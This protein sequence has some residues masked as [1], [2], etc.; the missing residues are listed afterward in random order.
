MFSS[1]ITLIST[2]LQLRRD[3]Q[4]DVDSIG[5]RL[6][7]IE[8]VHLNAITHSLW[9][10]DE[11]EL[12]ITLEGLYNLPDMQFLEI[13]DGDKIWATVGS[14][15]SSRVI[16][17]EYDIVHTHQNQQL[18]IGTLTA[19][20]NLDAV[21]GRLIDKTIIILISN[22][23]KTFLVAGF[24]LIFFHYLI[25]RH[26]VGISQYLERFVTD[27]N[28][29]HPN[30]KL[31]RDEHEKWDELDTLVDSLNKLNHELTSSYHS[32]RDSEEKYRLAMNATSD[33]LWDFRVS[34]GEVYYSPGW[35][36]I[37]DEQEVTGEYK[38]W[39]SRIHPMDKKRIL[40]TL[41]EHLKGAT[42]QWEEEHRLKKSDGTW[43]WVLGRGKV[44]ERNSAG[45][46]LRMIGTMTEISQRKHAEERL[47]YQATHDELTGLINRYEFEKRT[48]RLLADQFSEIDTHALLFMDL[49]QFKVINDV[50]GH[51]AGDELLRQVSQRLAKIVRK[52]DT[53]ARL[54]GDEFVLL[55]EHC[56]LDRA[57][58]IAT[59]IITSIRDLQFAWE[60]RTF[61]IGISIGLIEINDS[62]GNYSDLLKMADSAC[63]FAKD[64]GRNRYYVYDP[65][66]DDISSIQGSMQWVSRINEAIEE[67]R[68][69]LY[70]QPIVPTGQTIHNH[71]EILIRLISDDGKVIPPGAFLPAAERY[72]LINAI[73][74]WVV[75]QVFKTLEGQSTFMD[76]ID[77][78]SINLS[79]PSLTDLSFREHVRQ[80][81][82]N[83]SFPGSKICFEITETAAI[84]NLAAAND[85]I[86]SL[87]GLGCLFALDDF[88]SGLS[89]F[90]YL[91]NL[92]VDYLKIDGLFV[93]D[94]AEDMIDRAMVKSI[95]EVGHVL[96]KETIAEFVENDQIREI[97]KSIGVDYC[98]GYGIG[99][100]IPL[101]E[102]LAS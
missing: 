58:E 18:D 57:T 10:S 66:D 7:E 71:Y 84:S 62:T 83:S 46:P 90:G 45:E 12:Q 101:K 9:I 89:S 73:D 29:Y 76:S 2:G 53:L 16:Q 41:G 19:V 79:G 60:D 36:Q 92:S 26:L 80:T 50:C 6:S 35:N 99:K 20:A 81:V 78:I 38:S 88:G 98:Q 25:T 34:T 11:H 40:A 97:L 15:K 39:E 47:S 31:D 13:R 72:S 87:G 27:F 5:G 100:P 96:G 22:G 68:F 67:D 56:A 86:A 30:L 3:Y 49:D 48:K 43:I 91:R 4:L 102:L 37:L 51:H 32:L 75:D 85:F 1:L 64:Q 44:V 61:R 14:P 74:I 59:Q 70:A 63:F 52:R 21:L 77:F 54:G 55:M 65:G 24:I 17:R 28:A 93:K 42:K 69:V 94:I 95:N 82:E 23:F 33:G 8:T